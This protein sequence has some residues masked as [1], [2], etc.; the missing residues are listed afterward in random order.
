MKSLVLELHST[1]THPKF[2]HIFIFAPLTVPENSENEADALL[3]FTAE[4]SSRWEMCQ[5]LIQRSSKYFLAE[6]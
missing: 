5:V 3:H 1:I 4:F 2:D 6:V